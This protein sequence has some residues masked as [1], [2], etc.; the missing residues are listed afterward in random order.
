[1]V[2]LDGIPALGP[3]NLQYMGS[4]GM[5]MAY[6]SSTANRSGGGILNW[7]FRKNRVMEGEPFYVKGKG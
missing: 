4:P 5:S 3:S 7:F 2:P 1:M 6:I